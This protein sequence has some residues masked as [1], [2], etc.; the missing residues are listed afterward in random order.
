[1]TPNCNTSSAQWVTGEVAPYLKQRA[2]NVTANSLMACQYSQTG[3]F[4]SERNYSTPLTL[5]GKTSGQV[6]EKSLHGPAAQSH[7]SG[8]SYIYTS[9]VIYILPHIYR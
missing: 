8:L 6:W 9:R 3:M 5:L 1:M 7:S 4:G 2:P